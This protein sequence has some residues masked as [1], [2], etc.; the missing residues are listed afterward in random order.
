MLGSSKEGKIRS[1]PAY[2]IAG[3]AKTKQSMSL[4]FPG[5]GAYDAKMELSEP[6][7]PV[8]SMAC[9]LKT[10]T[11]AHMKPGPGAHSPEKVISFNLYYYNSFS[12][13]LTCT[14]HYIYTSKNEILGVYS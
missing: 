3:R 5:P 13:L 6:H 12:Y 11:D 14:T 7:A 10:P 8:Y 2:S 4:F 9:R 1:A